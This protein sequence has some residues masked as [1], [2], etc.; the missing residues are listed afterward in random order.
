MAKRIRLLSIVTRMNVGG[1][2]VQISTLMRGLLE[3]E[4]DQILVTGTVGPDEEDFLVDQGK[5]LR[6]LRVPSMSREV[7]PARDALAL[8]EISGIIRR[9]KPHVIHTHT[10]KAGSLGRTAAIL[11]RSEAKRVHTF[12]GH[13]LHGYFSPSA[14]R[15]VIAVE[16]A[17]AKRTSKLIAVGEQVKADLLSAGIGRSDQYE[18]I[19][20]GLQLGQIPSR[21]QARADLGLEPDQP[22]VC[23]IGRLTP[24]KRI[25][26]L[27]EVV[28]ETFQR[29]PEVAFLVAGEGTEF[30]SLVQARDQGLPIVALGWRSDVERILAASDLMVLTSDNEGTPVALIQAGLAGVPVVSTDVGSVKDVVLSGQTGILTSPDA[31]SLSREISYLISTPTMREQFGDFAR[32]DYAERYGSQTLVRSHVNVYRNLTDTA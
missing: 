2:A 7:S 18:V 14:T 28:R 3:T 11:T 20:P 32:R 5:D 8:R 17:L 6:F 30:D 10:A 21:A 16:R 22:V 27:I 4:V 1:P 24:I 25:D 29:I 19:P 13:L 12:H 15:R 23:F 26:R 31:S 9:F